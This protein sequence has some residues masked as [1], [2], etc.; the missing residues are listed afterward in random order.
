MAVEINGI[1]YLYV[2]DVAML[3]GMSEVTV[4]RYINKKRLTGTKYLNRWI[5]SK[6]DI[7]KFCKAE[8]LT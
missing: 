2:A 7:D 4:R 1:R 6:E 3:M 5:F 8:G